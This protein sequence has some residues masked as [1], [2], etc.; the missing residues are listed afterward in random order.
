MFG[1]YLGAAGP[2]QLFMIMHPFINPRPKIGFYPGC[3][4]GGSLAPNNCLLLRVGLLIRVPGYCYYYYYYYY[5][6]YDYY[7]DYYYDDYYYYYYYYY[8]Y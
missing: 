6:D 4:T 5:Y 2:K 3:L 1:F 7:Y 8:Y